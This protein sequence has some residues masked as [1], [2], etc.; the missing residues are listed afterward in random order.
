MDKP[1]PSEEP[2]IEAV[3]AADLD[4]WLNDPDAPIQELIDKL[5]FLH[6]PEQARSY[7]EKVKAG[8][9]DVRAGRTMSHEEFLARRAEQRRQYL[10]QRQG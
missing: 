10:A 4:P 3:D 5:P 8:M 9:E 2:G 7:L 1:L 6:S